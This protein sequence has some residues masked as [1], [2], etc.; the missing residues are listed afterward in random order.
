MLSFQKHSN[1]LGQDC[2][3]VIEK[4]KI[5]T[6]GVKEG[7]GGVG[8][9]WRFTARSVPHGM[10]NQLPS[11]DQGDSVSSARSE[12]ESHT[13]WKHLSRVIYM[14]DSKLHG[15]VKMVRYPSHFWKEIHVLCI[16]TQTALYTLHFYTLLLFPTNI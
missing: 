9:R 13:L 2:S 3:C 10:F 16:W 6:I 1:I 4:I 5:K 8:K 12:L 15:P 11:W 14:T 7:G